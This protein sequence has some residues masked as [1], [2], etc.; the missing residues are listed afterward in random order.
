MLN[1]FYK[2]IFLLTIL[3]SSPSISYGRTTLTRNDYYPL[4]TT[5]DPQSFLLRRTKNIL[6]NRE[7]DNGRKRDNFCFYLTPF[8]QNANVGRDFD[9]HDFPNCSCT[10]C[11]SSN[12]D[13]GESHLGSLN[14]RWS[15]IGLLMGDIPKH[16]SYGT[17][18]QEAREKI[19]GTS[20]TPTGTN[21]LCDSTA[22]DCLK[23]F[24]FFQFPGC[25]KKRGMRFHIS[26]AITDDFGIIV[27]GGFS[28]INL[29]ICMGCDN[30]LTGAITEGSC[31]EQAQNTYG[32]ENFNEININKYL[33]CRLPEIAQELNRNLC[34]YH[35]N[36]FEDVRAGVYWRHPFQV[37]E[38][39]DSSWP[40]F[41]FIPFCSLG[42]TLPSGKE[43][44]PMAPFSLPFGNNGHSAF[45]V[46]GGTNI[47]FTE[48]IEIGWE[49]GFTH[50][51]DNSFTDYPMPTTSL[52]RGIFPFTADVT[53]SPGM[54]WHFS[55]K[56]DA[57][58]FLDRLSFYFQWVIM[59]HKKD[60]FY[61]HGENSCSCSADCGTCRTACTLGC[62]TCSNG[63]GQVF[64]PDVLSCR[65][66]W[67]A[68]VINTALNY[69]ISPNVTLGFAWQAPISQRN[70]FRSTTVAFGVNLTF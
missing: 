18:L 55:L 31:L 50:F 42:F 64:K 17:N 23:K 2:K 21:P 36:S 3:L 46:Y 8:G 48:T 14:A 70:V 61:V 19:F 12:S 49:L 69:D 63:Q 10:D 54:N 5:M 6:Q 27:E 13:P 26:G 37:N 35:K 32:A 60:C 62:E 67:K 43:F 28:A 22:I 58:H 66:A 24:G 25:Y 51:F 34:D 38:D 47:D 20:Y 65:S 45:W 9:N 57:Y 1:R 59:E 56:M 16:K 52:Q 15:M 33:M 30:N 41:L 7:I 4:Y 11:G 68:Q 29:N 53:V 44:C 40:Q 39:R